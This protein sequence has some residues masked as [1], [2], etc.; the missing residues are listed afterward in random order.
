MQLLVLAVVAA[1]LAR[2]L[3]VIASPL[4]LPLISAAQG[5]GH[6]VRSQT[7]LGGQA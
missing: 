2:M 1:L 4:Y 7:D 6:K 5:D 3:A